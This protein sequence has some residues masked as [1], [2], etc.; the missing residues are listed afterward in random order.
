MF[1]CKQVVYANRTHVITEGSQLTIKEEIVIGEPCK[2]LHYFEPEEPDYKHRVVAVFEDG[3]K[4][5][6]F[7]IDEIS[8]I[9]V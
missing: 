7:D 6:I 5:I 2:A 9:E 1:D 4:R 8:G 3:I